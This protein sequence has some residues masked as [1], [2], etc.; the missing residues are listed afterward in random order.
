MSYGTDTGSTV[1][2]TEYNRT[3]CNVKM[4]G[5]WSTV[6]LSASSLIIVCLTHSTLDTLFNTF[7]SVNPFQLETISDQEL[8]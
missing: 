5:L 7:S 1:Y 4:I 6:V 2:H 8:H 3:K